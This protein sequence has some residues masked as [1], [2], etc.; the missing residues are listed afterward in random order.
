MRHTLEHFLSQLQGNSEKES[1]LKDFSAFYKEVKDGTLTT[2]TILETSGEETKLY[3]VVNRE[4]VRVK[5]NKNIK[6]NE[7]ILEALKLI[8]ENYSKVENIIR[9]SFDNVIVKETVDFADLNIISYISAL[10]YFNSFVQKYAIAQIAL[11]KQVQGLKVNKY[12]LNSIDYCQ[13]RDNVRAFGEIYRVVYEDLDKIAKSIKKIEG[14]RATP[15]FNPAEVGLRNAAIDPL[16]LGLV[17]GLGHIVRL[18]GYMRNSYIKN[19]YEYAKA[20][21]AKIQLE[22]IALE[23]MKEQGFLDATIE[24]QLKYYRNK[25]IELRAEIK[26]IEES[27]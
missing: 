7:A 2:Y 8:T 20:Q 21:A 3:S 24:K 12:E 15:D 25:V 4:I 11:L 9:T 6:N 10:K 22:I 18:F 27:V 26:D 16:K 14:I 13:N 19:R 5:K 1:V 23:Q 17:P